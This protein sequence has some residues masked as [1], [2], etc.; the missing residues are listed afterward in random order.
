MLKL[1]KTYELAEKKY[2]DFISS[3]TKAQRWAFFSTLLCGLV[4][5]IPAIANDLLNHDSVGNID[6]NYQTFLA[7]QGKWAAPKMVALLRGETST[8]SWFVMV[9]ILIFAVSAVLIVRMFKVKSPIAAMLLGGVLISSETTASM[10]LAYGTDYFAL[11]FL[12]AVIAAYITRMWKHGWILAVPTLAVALGGYQPELGVAAAL[13]VMACVLDC[14]FTDK[15]TPA[16]IF[17][18]IKYLAVLLA[19]GF[20][21][22]IFL[23]FLT[24]KGLLQ[25][26]SY[27]NVDSIS[28]EMFTQPKQVFRL[29]KDSVSFVYNE[30]LGHH[31]KPYAN[32]N[33]LY[34][35]YF[36]ITTVASAVSIVRARSYK[37]P[38]N[39]IIGLVLLLVFFPLAA[40]LVDF[41]TI[42][43]GV[44]P[45]MRYSII[46][47]FIVPL[48]LYDYIDPDAEAA[49][50][51]HSF[52]MA[53]PIK[54][55]IILVMLVVVINW[56]CLDHDMYGYV[57]A[58][59]QQMFAKATCLMSSIYDCDGYTS[60]ASVALIGNPRYPFFADDGSITG[61]QSARSLKRGTQGVYS[62]WDIF[63]SPRLLREC[64]NKRLGAG[65]T[66][67]D[68]DTVCQD[69]PDL[70]SSMSVYPNEGSIVYV[71]ESNTVIVKLSEI[72]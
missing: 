56:T 70:C 28:P 13:L 20:I 23:H 3:I 37:R 52:T 53:A 21:Y 2:H 4:A 46:L 68:G 24:S 49:K 22:Y 9:G 8:P 42:D 16:I 45:V 65:F 64:L 5:H 59:N 7:A 34:F 40:N 54:G 63:Y 25:L 36:A 61:T 35:V 12:L 11:C 33:T 71:A 44:S 41:L 60:E 51:D 15:K 57:S 32:L 17:Q 58:A 50:D 14:F 39:L 1:I 69:Y 66:Y 72:S 6:P 19:G 18:G 43:D 55:S 31:A 30:L 48:I 67:V 29:V 38:V 62:S 10:T 47:I 27:R 26:G